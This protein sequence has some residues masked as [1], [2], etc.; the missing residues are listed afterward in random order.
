MHRWPGI[1]P[2]LT[3]QSV[4]VSPLGMLHDARHPYN[5]RHIVAAS[6]GRR[7]ECEPSAS[8]RRVG[9]CD[10]THLNSD[11]HVLHGSLP[12]DHRS[13]ARRGDSCGTLDMTM[14]RQ[15]RLLN[16]LRTRMAILCAAALVAACADQ[17]FDPGLEPTVV[18]QAAIIDSPPDDPKS[19]ALAEAVQ[20]RVS[21]AAE[22]PPAEQAVAAGITIADTL[23]AVDAYLSTDSVTVGDT[24]TLHLSDNAG[25]VGVNRQ[26]QVAINRIG[27]VDQP[28]FA[29]TASMSR[30]VLPADAWVNCCN[31]PVALSVVIPVNWSSGLYRMSVTSPDGATTRTHFVVRSAAPGSTS[32]VALQVPF[33]TANAYSN[34]GGK[35]VYG[36]NSTNGVAAPSVSTFRPTGLAQDDDFSRWTY[37]LI[38]WAESQGVALEYLSS[39]DLNARPNVLSPYRLFLTVGHDEYWSAERRSELNRFVTSG[40]NAAILSGNT[41]WWKVDFVTDSVGRARGRMNASKVPGSSTANWYEVNPEAKLIGATWLKGGY[42][43]EIATPAL[44]DIG[45]SVHVPGSYAFAGLGLAPNSV[46]GRNERILRYEADGIDFTLNAAGLPVATG[47]DGAPTD[48][49]ILASVALNG[50]ESLGNNPP[51]NPNLNITGLPGGFATITSHAVP[52]GGTVFNASTTD[53]TRAL[54]PCT[55]GGNAASPICGITRNVINRLSSTVANSPPVASVPESQATQRGSVVNLQL[56]A[57]DADNDPL[58]FSATGLPQGLSISPSGLISGSPTSAATSSNV[59]VVVSDGLGGKATFQIAWTITGQPGGQ[60]A[61]LVSPAPGSQLAAGGSATFT[62]TPG[63][64]DLFCLSV[65][66]PGLP[67]LFSQCLTGTSVTVTGLPQNGETLL[68]SLQTRVNL[69]WQP[70]VAYSFTAA[71]NVGNV[72]ASLVSPTPN[73]VLAPGPTTFSW[74]PGDGDLY[75]LSIDSPG[76]PSLFA[77]CTTGTSLVASALP[78]AGEDIRVSL[79]TRI[80][81]VWQP[82]VGYRYTAAGAP[83]TPVATMIAP[84][85]GSTLGSGTTQFSWTNPG[86]DLYCLSVESTSVPTIFDQCMVGTSAQVSG[87]PT[88]GETVIVN[89]QTRQNLIWQ[90]AIEYRYVTVPGG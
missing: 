26:A 32:R 62:W 59:V 17:G 8:A 61:S 69:I 52:N 7:H 18:E 38:R 41:M 51:V 3:V 48:T 87:L 16:G 78:Q 74:S 55:A 46:I 86:G 70:A 5:A 28:V 19:V 13:S 68:V 10:Q 15:R 82:A 49:I 37:P 73:S 21:T 66:S 88:T 40:G 47:G 2:I 60:L 45:F 35:S 20:S 11:E 6:Q 63:S 36:F 4:T 84:A 9:E 53:W 27:Q 72:V 33:E 90:P 89:L 81:L 39:S 23:G 58:H 42:V 57:S 1:S 12:P 34:W 14:N 71:T 83:V 44:T 24:L 65:D 64:G 50:W 75:C 85:S 30:Q 43:D 29:A 80:N 31:W 76:L 79:Q 77:E 25:T 54:A 56:V 22:S 67:S